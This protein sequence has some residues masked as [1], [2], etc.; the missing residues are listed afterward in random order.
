MLY[1]HPLLLGFAAM[2]LVAQLDSGTAEKQPSAPAHVLSDPKGWRGFQ[3]DMTKPQAEVLGAKIISDSQG[4]E[5][6]GLEDVEVLP[7]KNRFGVD[8]QF[9]SHIGLTSILVKMQPHKICARDEYEIILN[10]LRV[11]YGDEKETK[12]LDYPNAFF[13]SH[14]WVAGAT[15]ITLHHSCSKPGSPSSSNKSFLTSIHY[16][17]RLFFELWNR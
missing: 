10:D 12:N 9:F 2:G 11:K 1:F 4:E 8:L 16:E 6:F 7:G 17:K 5:R 15:K 3:W 14:V 13:M